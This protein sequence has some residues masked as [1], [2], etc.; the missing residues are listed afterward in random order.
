MLG[1]RETWHARCAHELKGEELLRGEAFPDAIARGTYPVDIHSDSGTILRYL[2]GREEV[3]ARDG[4]KT[5]RRWR[6]ES[7]LT[8]P[9]YSVPFRSLVPQN[10]KNLL[11][12]GRLIDADAQ[13]FGGVR[14]MV[15]CNQM[16]EAAGVAA[17]LGVQCGL[18]AAQI[19]AARLR[20]T[21]GAGGSL[22]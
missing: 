8:P 7:E 17:F 9:F 14:V 16:G 13:A 21:L 15:N 4:S 18:D 11:I 1:V 12:A 5:W 19:D 2:D 10:A 22:L 20:Q 6:D 3:V